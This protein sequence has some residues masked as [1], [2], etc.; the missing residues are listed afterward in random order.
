MQNWLPFDGELGLGA[1][2]ATPLSIALVIVLLRVLLIPSIRGAVR[3][4]AR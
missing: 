1:V 2:T 3:E 4:P